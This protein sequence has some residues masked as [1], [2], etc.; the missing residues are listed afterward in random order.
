VSATEGLAFYRRKLSLAS[1]RVADL[2]Y[3]IAR[4][5]EDDAEAAVV[6]SDSLAREVRGRELEPHRA[7]A[8]RQRA[9]LGAVIDAEAS[10]LVALE[11]IAALEQSVLAAI[12]HA[13]TTVQAAEAR[14]IE[15]RRLADGARSEVGAAES[16]VSSVAG[17]VAGVM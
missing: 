11:E 7:A 4:L 3:A 8:Q 12:A 13:R 2:S 16:A 14:A 6:W 17:M 9:A 5:E 1:E 15:S 10:I